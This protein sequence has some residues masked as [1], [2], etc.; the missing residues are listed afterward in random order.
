M[1]AGQ[2]EIPVLTLIT[3]YGL[4]KSLLFD[5]DMANLEVN[6]GLLVG[7]F[8]LIPRSRSGSMNVRLHLARVNKYGKVR[9][10]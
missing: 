3:K 6:V 7:I 5:G 9:G 1:A 10:R 8:N 4:G 2:L